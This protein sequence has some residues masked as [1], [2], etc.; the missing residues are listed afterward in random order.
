MTPDIKELARQLRLA[1]EPIR[2]T[3]AAALETLAGEVDTLQMKLAACGVG[4]LSN[5]E[6]TIKDNRIGP[7]SP[8][9]SAS[10]G[11]VYQIV[12]KEMEARA[13]RDRLK[14]ALALF[15]AIKADDGDDFSTYDDQVVIRCE[16]TAGDLRKARTALG[17]AS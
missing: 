13:E 3:A 11:D 9:W 15:A 16:V 17:E 1:R 8:Y 7:D 14:A 10:L 4:A 5:T 2:H 6:R 12:D